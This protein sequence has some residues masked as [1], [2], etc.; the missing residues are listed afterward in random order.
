LTFQQLAK[1]ALCRLLIAAWLQKNID[2]IPVLVNGALKIL[3][4]AS[5]CYE[6]F[7]QVPNVTQT[8]LPVLESAD[9][10]G[11]EFS[12]PLSNSFVSDHDSAIRQ[13][14]F[15]ISQAQAES[16]IEPNGIADD[17]LRE[18]MAVIV[19]RSI[20]CHGNSLPATAST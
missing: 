7:I 18:T 3:P 20:G 19:A 17:I 14:I 16:V 15:D 1:K 8:S 9:I 12:A 10:F 11:T 13:K 5:D 4:F 2:Q 6:K